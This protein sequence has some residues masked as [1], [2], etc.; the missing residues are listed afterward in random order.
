MWLS[1]LSEDQLSDAVSAGGGDAGFTETHIWVPPMKPIE[2]RES[3]VLA[4]VDIVGRC[5]DLLRRVAPD[6]QTHR[7]A[8]ASVVPKGPVVR[9][10]PVAASD[11]ERPSPVTTFALSSVGYACE[12]TD[13][14]VTE[15]LS[16]FF[17]NNTSF[18][19]YPRFYLD[20]AI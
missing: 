17:K 14:G 6:V 7:A 10:D 1:G 2:E 3:Q 19:F 5:I 13:T 16:E 11:I 12:H 9:P 18:L 8:L 4:E 15:P 20:Y